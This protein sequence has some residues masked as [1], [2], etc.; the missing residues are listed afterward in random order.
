MVNLERAGL[1]SDR[2]GEF[3]ERSRDPLG[4]QNLDTN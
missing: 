1:G 2:L 4:R 3:G